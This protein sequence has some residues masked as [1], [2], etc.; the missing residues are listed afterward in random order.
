MVNTRDNKGRFSTPDKN[1]KDKTAGRKRGSYGKW[2]TKNNTTN[3]ENNTKAC[4][5]NTVDLTDT[6]EDT[7]W[8]KRSESYDA[9]TD[10]ELSMTTRTDIST[11]EKRVES[12]RELVEKQGAKIAELE[13][14]LEKFTACDDTDTENQK[15][16]ASDSEDEES[17]GARRLRH[18]EI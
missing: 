5:S 3:R 15:V 17:D 6:K 9:E 7:H 10:D 8:T 2:I 16:R 12:L 13:N 11:I 14:T 1:T 18:P 4:R